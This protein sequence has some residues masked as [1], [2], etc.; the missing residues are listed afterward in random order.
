VEPSKDRAVPAKTVR[1][2][3]TTGGRFRG[4]P[5]LLSRLS[6]T[7]PYRRTSGAAAWPRRAV[8]QGG[9]RTQTGG[10]RL[11]GLRDLRSPVRRLSWLRRAFRR[12]SVR[13]RR[14]V[15]DA[16]WI[17]LT[18]RP[19]MP[20]LRAT[21][22]V[23][24]RDFADLV[25]MTGGLGHHTPDTAAWAWDRERQARQFANGRTRQLSNAPVTVCY[26]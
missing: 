17:A 1:P 20:A 4:A 9:F 21:V 25:Q 14:D 22:V 3:S 26:G 18:D 10:L 15:G 8:N 12:V 24:V 13:Q 2:W 6:E 16:R 5:G 11:S 23:D 19:D 7:W